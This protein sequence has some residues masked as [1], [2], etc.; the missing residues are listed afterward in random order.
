MDLYIDR[1]PFLKILS[2][3]QSV[4]ERRNTIPILANTLLTAQEGRL[5]LAATDLEVSL[6]TSC[7]ADVQTEGCLSVS[8]RKLFDIVRELPS[9]PVRLRMDTCD[10]IHLTC[11]KAR[12][13]LVGLPGD[14]FP[15]LPKPD[16]LIKMPLASDVLRAMFAKTHFAMSQEESRFTL[17]GIFIV[18]DP[19]ENPNDPCCLRMVATDTHRLSLA[20]TNLE[21]SL[22]EPISAI[23]P[24]KAVVEARKILDEETQPLEL[25]LGSTHIQFIRPEITLISKLVEGRFPNYNKVIPTNNDIRLD[26]DKEHLLSVVRRMIVL[27]NE[28]SHGIRTKINQETMKV[29]TTNP[30]QEAA[31]EEMSIRYTGEPITLGFNARYLQEILAAIDGT[32]ICLRIQ[33]HE[34]SVLIEDPQNNNCLFVLMPMRV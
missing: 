15:E 29:S 12:F 33:N 23:I 6:L 1:D 14:Q 8:A 16:G 9:E 27:S 22:E 2:R 13:N 19:G 25:V 21:I 18:V 4:A 3:I 7:A 17:N 11:G 26:I 32:D 20:K 28:K 31:D 5:F 24:R 30:E 34:S 10:R